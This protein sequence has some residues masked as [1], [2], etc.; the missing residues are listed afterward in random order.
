MFF[1][2]KMEKHQRSSGEQVWIYRR[3]TNMAELSR[4]NRFT[5][6][7][8]ESYLYDRREKVWRVKGDNPNLPN[9]KEEEF[10]DIEKLAKILDQQGVKY[11]IIQNDG[12]NQEE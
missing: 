11:S 2:E 1:A 4:N 5:F 8:Y 10:D 6:A 12:V 9:Y 7:I 3:V